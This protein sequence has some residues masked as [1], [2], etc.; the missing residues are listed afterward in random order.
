MPEQPTAD[1]P[2]REGTARALPAQLERLERTIGDAER[3]IE[4]QERMIAE[5]ALTG[6]DTARE[7]FELHKMQLLTL[8][9]REGRERLLDPSP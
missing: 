8:I 6:R 9:L 4:A 1:H 2:V 7:S 3:R 5:G